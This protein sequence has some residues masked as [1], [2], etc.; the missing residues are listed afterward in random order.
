M[1]ALASRIVYE[2]SKE[3]LSEAELLR[4]IDNK[5]T[6]QLMKYYLRDLVSLGII[7]KN[8]RRGKYHLLGESFI[9]NGRA[10]VVKDGFPLFLECPYYGTECK[11][12]QP[13][14]EKGK[15]CRFIRELPSFLKNIFV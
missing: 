5:V 11:T 7:K 1:K 15:P 14:D 10:I 3:D 13:F 8:E 9:V 12:C 6:H 4:K 2:L